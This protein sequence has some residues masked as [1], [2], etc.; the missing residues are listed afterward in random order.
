MKS[1]ITAIVFILL[2]AALITV[3]IIFYPSLSSVTLDGAEKVYEIT[4]PDHN[5]KLNLY[6]YGGVLFKRDYTYIGEVENL[7]TSKKKNILWLPPEAEKSE[8]KWIDNKTLMVGE[9]KVRI[10]K[11]MYDFR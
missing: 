7:N 2:I 5:Y 9:R 4:S 1:K 10:H 6:L 11:D 8:I 3:K